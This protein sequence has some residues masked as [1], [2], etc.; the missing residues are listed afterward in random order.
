[1][2]SWSWSRIDWPLTIAGLFFLVLASAAV[3]AVVTGRWGGVLVRILPD[4]STATRLQWWPELDRS[5]FYAWPLAFV[6]FAGGSILLG[7]IHSEGLYSSEAAAWAQAVGVVASVLA[8]LL[9]DALATSRPERERRR[10]EVH[11]A[12]RV[13]Y[14]VKRMHQAFQEAGQR[15]LGVAVPAL[16]GS[17]PS[18]PSRLQIRAA[19]QALTALSTRPDELGLQGLDLITRAVQCAGHWRAEI[20]AVR[21]TIYDGPHPSIA[22]CETA[23]KALAELEREA[24]Q[25][26]AAASRR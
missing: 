2:Q 16:A 23:A 20:E 19:E 24:F 3:A 6:V 26:V 10:R 13:L 7:A 17:D 4:G 18:D 22:L 21:P 9:G 8:I 15:R 1:M 11:Q 5:Y 12:T 14:A 25:L